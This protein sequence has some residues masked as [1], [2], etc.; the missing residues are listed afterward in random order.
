M[1]STTPALR[2]TSYRFHPGHVEKP[3]ASEINICYKIW[4][5]AQ[6]CMHGTSAGCCQQGSAGTGLPYRTSSAAA[7][8]CQTPCAA[9]GE[10]GS[11]AGIT[12]HSERSL[13][14]AVT[15]PRSFLLRNN[16]RA[17]EKKAKGKA[18]HFSLHAACIPAAAQGRLSPPG[19]AAAAPCCTAS[20]RRLPLVLRAELRGPNDAASLTAGTWAGNR[21]SFHQ[22]K[23]LPSGLMVQKQTLQK[24]P[25]AIPALT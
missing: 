8:L 10:A 9:W 16:R 3:P 18:G 24:S 19:D 14:T 5:W 22:K 11:R 15:A 25:A 20:S 12:P 23:K 4:P 1:P 7:A 13:A 6:G 17:A 21:G 2:F